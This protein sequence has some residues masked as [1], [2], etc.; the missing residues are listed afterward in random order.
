MDDTIK[1]LADVAQ[2]SNSPAISILIAVLLLSITAIITLWFQINKERK[3]RNIVIIEMAREL[4]T[5]STNSISAIVSLK[6]ISRQ[7]REDII[8]ELKDLSRKIEGLKNSN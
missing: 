7:Q 4:I 8:S 2:N 5:T 6:D 3:E 1:T